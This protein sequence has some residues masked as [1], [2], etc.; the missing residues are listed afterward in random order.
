MKKS[1]QNIINDILKKIEKELEYITL[2]EIIEY[3]GFSYFHFHRIFFAYVG[4]NLKQYIK[5]I[6]LEKAAYELQYQKRSITE[7]ALKAGFSTPSAF[8]KAFKEFFHTTPSKYK[9]INLRQKEF[10]MIEPVEIIENMEPIEVY[11]IRHVGDYNKIGCAFERLMR[12]AYTHKIKNGKDMMGKGAYTY[13]IGYDDPNVTD[14]DK[15]R[16]DACVSATDEVPLEDGIFKQSISGGKYAVFLHRGEYFKLI[17]TYNNIFSS[18]IKQ[19]DIK[20][21]DVPTFERYLNHDPRRTK[22]ENLKTEIHIP[23]E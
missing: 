16:S 15:L 4:E 21:R 9:K 23:I 12:W 11:S 1:N 14:I 17:D 3:S 7:V 5:R 22:P 2:D 20:L 8:N 19:N 18:Y 10:N 13:G 6:R